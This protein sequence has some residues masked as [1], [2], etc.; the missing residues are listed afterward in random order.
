MDFKN[1][2]P[3]RLSDVILDYGRYLR[4][5]SV[6]LRRLLLLLCNLSCY[7]CYVSKISAERAENKA[8]NYMVTVSLFKDLMILF[9]LKGLDRFRV[10]S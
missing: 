7:V 2:N 1:L 4:F 6:K 9:G 10:F 3:V 8:C 5:K